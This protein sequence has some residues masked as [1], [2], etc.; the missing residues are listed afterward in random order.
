L[1][2]NNGNNCL[3]FACYNNLAALDIVKYLVGKCKMNVNFKNIFGNNC[4]ILACVKI[5]TLI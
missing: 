4:L 1:K 5:Q 3:L 2:N